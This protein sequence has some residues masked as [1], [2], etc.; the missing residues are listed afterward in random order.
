MSHKDLPHST[1]R[2]GNRPAGIVRTTTEES[3]VTIASN[4]DK[5]VICPGD[6]GSGGNPQTPIPFLGG[7]KSSLG[8]PQSR[9]RK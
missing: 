7:L 3:S 4:V 6:V 1:I 8:C 9:P 2:V 5:V